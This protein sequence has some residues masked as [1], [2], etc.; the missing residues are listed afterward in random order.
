MKSSTNLEKAN[1]RNKIWVAVIGGL[2]TI[3]AGSFV[4]LSTDKTINERKQE[5]NIKTN[6]NSPIS[7]AVQTQNNYYGI[8][9]NQKPLDETQKAEIENST[10]IVSERKAHESQETTRTNNRNLVR[11]DAPNALIVT[12]N[13]S[14]GTNTVNVN[15]VVSAK[16][17]VRI[18]SIEA[19][20]SVLKVDIPLPKS[21]RLYGNISLPAGNFYKH[22]F[23]LFCKANAYEGNI[24]AMALNSEVI[25]FA[26]IKDG[27]NNVIRPD[28]DSPNPIFLF[29][30]EDG[31]LEVFVYTKNKIEDPYSL[32]VADYDR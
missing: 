9:P 20:I 24:A 12:Q 13:Q 15:P 22:S 5:N 18:L 1:R 8:T 14:G 3:I 23:K 29:H 7:N 30:P 11:T 21:G 16:P 27:Y 28:F 10:E 25:H 2:A 32:F 4:F 17:N 19:N 6:Q 31:E 26:I